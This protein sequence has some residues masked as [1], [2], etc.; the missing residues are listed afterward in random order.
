MVV[1][2]TIFSCYYD[3]AEELYP[4]G[5]CQTDSVTYAAI[6]LPILQS[7]CYQCHDA[8][9]NLG[10]ITLEGYSNV[11]FYVDNGLLMGAINHE[12][13]FSPMPK[14]RPRLPDCEIDQIESW[15]ADG[16][17]DN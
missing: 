16:A 15:I 11:K 4:P 3:V 7:R 13:G 12:S 10:D 5:D 6:V 14:D 9:N 2:S 17:Q 8:A 1:F